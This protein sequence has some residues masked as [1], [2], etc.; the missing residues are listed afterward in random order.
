MHE[1]D[2]DVEPPLHAA[3]VAARDAVGGVAKPDE[4][5]QLVDPRAERRA[6]HAV[7]AA[8]QHEVLAPGRLPVDARVLRDVADRAADTVRMPHDVFARDERAARVGLRQ[9]RKR[10]NGRRLAGAVRPEQAENLA[11]AH[12]ERDA[13]ERLHVLVALPK[14]LGDDRVHVRRC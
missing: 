11:L 8:L 14:V 1:A 3:R 4:L 13:V 6:R 5:E 12:G 2:R 9:R 10:A 7:D